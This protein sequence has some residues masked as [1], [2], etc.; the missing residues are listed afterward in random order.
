[1]GALTDISA[2]GCYAVEMYVPPASGIEFEMA[3]EVHNSPHGGCFSDARD[4]WPT[5]PV[6]SQDALPP[7]G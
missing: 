4:V 1:M 5:Y 3:L 2:S 6:P 7:D